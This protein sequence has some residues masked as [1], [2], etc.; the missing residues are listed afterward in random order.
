VSDDQNRAP[1]W[2]A[3]R[4]PC[5]MKYT[6]A[7]SRFPPTAGHTPPHAC[8]VQDAQ[9]IAHSV[10]DSHLLPPFRKAEPFAPIFTRSPVRPA[11]VTRRHI[12]AS[13]KRTGGLADARFGTSPD[14]APPFVPR[15]G[16]RHDDGWFSLE[17][18]AE[19][20]VD[21]VV[22]PDLVVGSENEQLDVARPIAK[23]IGGHASGC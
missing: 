21:V 3:A 15:M 7:D 19:D 8:R 10:F 13:V 5:R 4:V 14:Q 16:A 20:S 22:F 6:L 1:T 9:L 17:R 12:P 2:A 23:D 11:G 18:Y